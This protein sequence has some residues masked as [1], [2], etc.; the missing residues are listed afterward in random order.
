MTVLVFVFVGLIG[1]VGLAG[2][3]PSPSDSESFSPT[4]SQANHAVPANRAP[5]VSANGPEPQI[6]VSVSPDFREIYYVYDGH[7]EPG[8]SISTEL[9]E[10]DE[11]KDTYFVQTQVSGPGM[12]LVIIDDRD[13]QANNPDPEFLEQ[14]L[15]GG[16]EQFKLRPAPSD[17][18]TLMFVVNRGSAPV[19]LSIRVDRTGSR[20]QSVIKPVAEY[21]SLIPRAVAAEYNVPDLRIDVKPCGFVNAIATDDRIVVCSELI[22]DLIA[23]DEFT[24]IGPIIAHELAHK[25]LWSWQ[26]PGWDDEDLADEFAGV[27]FAQIGGG[28]QGELDALIRWLE[29]RDPVAERLAR[30]LGD[31]HSLGIDRAMALRRVLANPAPYKSEWDARLASFKRE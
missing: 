2:C 26:I 20:P 29:R 31:T 27:L 5:T 4:Q 7:L 1:I 24:A 25:L 22:S 3:G 9:P 13:R 21:V 6:R 16:E 30:N 14:H 28:P 11:G 8:E 17:Q 12:S 19:R 23:H 10:F 18:G 15:L